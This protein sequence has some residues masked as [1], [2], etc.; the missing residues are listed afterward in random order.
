MQAEPWTEFRQ[1][2]GLVFRR[3][4]DVGLSA[5]ETDPELWNI[6]QAEELTLITDNRDGETD[7]SLQATILRNNTPQSLPI[8]TIADMSEFRVNGSYVKRAVKVLFE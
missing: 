2:L 1:D 3:L 4:E 8:F 5:S 7:D 6:C